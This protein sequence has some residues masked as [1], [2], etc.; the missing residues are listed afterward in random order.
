M[1]VFVRAPQVGRVKTRLT[2]RLDA[3]RV[4][5]LYRCFV[6]DILATLANRTFHVIVCHDPPG[7]E[8]AMKSWLGVSRDFMAQ[9]GSSLGARMAHAFQ[10]VFAKGVEQAVL[11]G[12]DFPDLD[13][14]VIHEAFENLPTHDLVVGPAVDGGYYLIGFNAGSF[15][16]HLFENMPWGT[17]RV[18][19][20]TVDGAKMAG[21]RMH[22]LPAW[23]DIDTVDDL[24]DFFARAKAKGM[25]HL[26]TVQYL[27]RNRTR[28]GF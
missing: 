24:K 3:Q 13:A 8:I 27:E 25:V 11:V 15:A 6:E 17:S 19:D 10:A 18:L 7:A 1:L 22:R 14:G 12:S 21:L 4:L 5:E 16:P 2:G 20:K 28:L 26:K 9:R 23:R